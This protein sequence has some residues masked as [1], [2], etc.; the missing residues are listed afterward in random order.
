MLLF[1][2]VCEQSCL[3][4]GE[5]IEPNVCKCRTGYE[6]PSCEKDF[7]ECASPS[8]GCKSTSD[9]VNMPGW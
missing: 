2:A 4:G 3:N 6:G 8:H 9:C 5:C 7:D 1:L